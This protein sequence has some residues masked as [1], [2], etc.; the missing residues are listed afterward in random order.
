[1][2]S[3]PRLLCRFLC[4][5]FASLSL[6][7]NYSVGFSKIRNLLH[8]WL[9]WF[10]DRTVECISG[11]VEEDSSPLLTAFFLIVLSNILY[12]FP[13]PLLTSFRISLGFFLPYFLLRLPQPMKM[14]VTSLRLFLSKHYLFC[15]ISV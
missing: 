11:F 12:H 3:C 1:V 15:Y 2:G 8:G 5:N 4:L 9:A 14:I 7:F 10:S 13:F 6:L